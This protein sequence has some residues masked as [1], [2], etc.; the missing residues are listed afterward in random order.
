MKVKLQPLF[1]YM[2]SGLIERTVPVRL[3]LLAA[4][5]GEHFLLLGPPGTA[6]S[7][8][9]RKLYRVFSDINYFERMLTRFS[10]PEELFGPLSIKALEEDRYHRLTENYMPEASIAFIDEIF[11]ANSAI[12]NSLLTLLN[13]REFDNGCERIKTPLLS[14]IAASNELAEDEGLDALYDR[15]LFRY[16]LQPVSDSGFDALLNVSFSSNN[17]SDLLDKLTVDDVKNI[18]I[19][20][21]PI[22]LNRAAN[23]LILKLRGYLSENEIYISDRRWRK[24]LKILKVCAYTNDKFVI[25]EWDCLLLTHLMWQTPDQ[26]ESLNKWFIES[27]DLDISTSVNRIEKLVI[28][29]EQQLSQD[30]QKHTQKTNL[31]GEALY[32]TPEGK[33]TTQHE[34]ITLAERDGQELYLAPVDQQDR[35]NNGS[36]YTLYQLEKAFFDDSFKQTHIN[37]RW[38]NIQNYINNSQNRLVEREAYEA[39]VEAYHF[40]IEYLR[41]QHAELDEV[42]NDIHN[43]NQH[44]SNAKSHL[45]E[46]NHQ[47][48]WLTGGLILTAFNDITDKLSNIIAQEQRLKALIVFNASLKPEPVEEASSLA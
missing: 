40:P 39:I 3:S 35:T 43:I 21:A 5:S 25:D 42:V 30:Q 41:S 48:L 19:K 46:I 17:N 16:Q 8:M 24:A 9:A 34:R 23:A 37:G 12:L 45:F 31:H 10:V 33:V 38:V 15:F 44:F 11:K 13:E 26:I 20:S 28:A 6:K 47:H 1:A 29:W 2:E 22:K 14:V 36:G 27:L 32:K 4:L 18:Q 7:E